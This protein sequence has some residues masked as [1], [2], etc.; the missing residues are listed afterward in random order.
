VYV[1]AVNAILKLVTVAKVRPT[2]YIRAG[3]SLKLLA[4]SRSTT[5][6]KSP[7]SSTSLSRRRVVFFLHGASAGR[8]PCLQADPGVVDGPSRGRRDGG[9]LV[10]GRLDEAG[11]GR[12]R[13]RLVVTA[14][15]PLGSRAIERLAVRLSRNAE[16]CERRT[17]R[18]RSGPG[19]RRRR[20]P[21]KLTTDEQG[22]A[23]GRR[24]DDMSSARLQQ[25][26]VNA[27]A[28]S[29]KRRLQRNRNNRRQRN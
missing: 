4:A 26:V 3:A 28:R 13:T 14:A 25:R 6:Y 16:L 1:R 15:L 11:G 2:R 17:V 29:R 23:S 21:D 12:R 22:T 24:R 7:K 8:C 20:R 9:V 10:A 18:R 27:A 19:R 5:F